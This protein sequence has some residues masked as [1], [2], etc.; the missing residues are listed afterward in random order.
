MN[1]EFK[2]EVFPAGKLK[3]IEGFTCFSTEGLETLKRINEN[4]LSDE[5]DVPENMTADQLGE[6]RARCR[7]NLNS[8]VEELSKR[9]NGDETLHECSSPCRCNEGELPCGIVL[10]PCHEG[11][12]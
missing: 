12:S 4:I 11:D 6:L 8:I 3:K 2:S 9:A 1:S 10:G 7:T 5:F